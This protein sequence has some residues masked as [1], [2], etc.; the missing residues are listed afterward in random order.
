MV[1]IN[2]YILL[3]CLIQQQLEYN[4]T[5]GYHGRPNKDKILV[6]GTQPKYPYTIV[7]N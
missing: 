6:S 1:I 2:A 5:I 4:I 7:M 3:V